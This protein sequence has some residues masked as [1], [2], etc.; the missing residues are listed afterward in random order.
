MAGISSMASVQTQ[1]VAQQRGAGV[2]GALRMK[3]RAIDVLALY[4][5]GERNAVVDSS[6]C[7][8]VDHGRR[9][10]VHEVKVV[11]GRE[12][13]QQRGGPSDVEAVP[14]HVRHGERLVSNQPAHSA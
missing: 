13:L 8:V 10:A 3:L 12:I 5:C 9:V 6:Q 1:K 11:A 14:A 2:R 4:D 7:E